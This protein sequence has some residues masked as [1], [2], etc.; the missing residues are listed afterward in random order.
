MRAYSSDLRIRIDEARQSGETTAEVAERFG[1]CTAFVRQL[2]QQFRETGSLAQRPFGR[3]SARKLAGHKE[4]LR[5]GVLEHPDAT[6]DEPR[7]R[8]R[9]PASR[10]MV[11]RTM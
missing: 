3:G 5:R 7:E 1:V 8:L 2:C 10:V 4:A 6:P 11:W 9:L